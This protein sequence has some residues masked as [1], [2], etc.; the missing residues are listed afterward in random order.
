MAL[1]AGATRCYLVSAMGADPSSRVF[2]NRTKGEVEAEIGRLPFRT[3]V[4]FRP[5]LLAGDRAEF[6]SGERAALA[7]LRPLAPVLPARWRPVSAVVVARAMLACAKT[8]SPGRFVVESD[9][10]VRLAAA[11]AHAIAGD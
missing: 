5:S 3:V 6:R 4:A 7:V 9:A 8:D 2:Y 11:G 10:I 1:A